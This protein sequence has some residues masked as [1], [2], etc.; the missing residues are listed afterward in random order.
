MCVCTC[1]CTHAPTHG[2]FALTLGLKEKAPSLVLF[3]FVYLTPFLLSP[4]CFCLGHLQRAHHIPAIRND[5]FITMTTKDIACPPALLPMPHCPSTAVPRSCSASALCPH[6][7]GTHPLPW[8][9]FLLPH[10]GDHYHPPWNP[11]L[12]PFSSDSRFFPRRD[13]PR[14]FSFFSFPPGFAR[15]S[16]KVSLD[17]A[18]PCFGWELL[19][20]FLVGPPQPLLAQWLGHLGKIAGTEGCGAEWHW[21]LGPV[22]KEKALS[23]WVTRQQ[24]LFQ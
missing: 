22:W 16:K 14:S 20:F 9:S 6:A 17:N 7:T 2:W 5:V 8:A 15:A 1:M 23:H 4:G 19:L 21:G 10:W 11:W 12:S 13:A 24:L 18:E 3:S